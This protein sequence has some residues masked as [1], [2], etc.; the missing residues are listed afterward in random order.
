MRP[1]D[2]CFPSLD[3]E[4]P[5]L[6]GFRTRHWDSRPS[7]V[8][9]IRRFTTPMIRFGG[10]CVFFSRRL[11]G[12]SLPRDDSQDRASGIPVASLDSPP[13]DRLFDAASLLRKSPRAAK[14]ALSA[15]PVTGLRHPRSGMPS[16]AR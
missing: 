3:Y 8:R 4:H 12:R 11:S 10:P 6:V 15:I 9:R 13:M 1:I 2:F 16:I 14:T 7:A 5:Y